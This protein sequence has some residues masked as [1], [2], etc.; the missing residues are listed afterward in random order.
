[1]KQPFLPPPR[2]CFNC[3]SADNY[4]EQ[5]RE[6][7]YTNIRTTI[8]AHGV[9]IDADPTDKSPKFD[10]FPYNLSHDKI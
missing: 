7:H 2:W 6:N 8:F 9:V 3:N 1:M 10:Y 5:L 4:R